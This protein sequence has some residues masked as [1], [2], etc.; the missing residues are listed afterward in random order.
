MLILASKKCLKHEN[1]F[2]QLNTEQDVTVCCRSDQRL[3]LG[4]HPFPNLLYQ[5]HCGKHVLSEHG[6][7]KLYAGVL[8]DDSAA[9]CVLL[10]APAHT[11]WLVVAILM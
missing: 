5:M 8:S 6:H 1:L 4:L 11:S 9:A 3:S 10:L 2:V 7:S